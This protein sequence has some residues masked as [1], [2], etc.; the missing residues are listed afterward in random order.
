MFRDFRAFSE[1]R[2]LD[3]VEA[4]ATILMDQEKSARGSWPAWHKAV[5]HSCG[6]ETF[7]FIPDE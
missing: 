7:Y 2:E 3:D 5:Q 1:G 6:K 4:A